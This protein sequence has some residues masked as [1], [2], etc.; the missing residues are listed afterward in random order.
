[1]RLFERV[2]PIKGQVNPIISGMGWPFVDRTLDA[3]V[4]HYIG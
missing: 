3:T 1:M 2:G 4:P